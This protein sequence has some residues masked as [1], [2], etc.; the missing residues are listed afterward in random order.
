MVYSLNGYTTISVLKKKDPKLWQGDPN[1][2]WNIYMYVYII[3][4]KCQLVKNRLFCVK[5]CQLDKGPIALQLH[6][7]CHR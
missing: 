5:K 3:Y 2:E 7:E 4:I 1:V 6:C